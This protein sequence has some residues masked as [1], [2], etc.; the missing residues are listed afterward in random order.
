MSQ[1]TAPRS[2]EPLP[3]VI[4]PGYFAAATE[5]REMQQHLQALGYPTLVVPLRVADWYPTVGG[6]PVTPI[7][8]KIAETIAKAQQQFGVAQV[9]LVGHSAGGWISR[10][11]LGDQPYYDQI[12]GG[13]SQ[14][15]SLITLGTPHVSQERWTRF[16]LNFVND[17]YPGAHW[18]DLKYVCVAGKACFGVPPKVWQPNTWSGWLA[19]SSYQLTGGTGEVWGDGITPIT[20]AHLEGA[21]NL[22]VESV[23]HSPRGNRYWYGSA[24]VLA[25]WVQYLQ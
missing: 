5:Y 17:N 2:P 14:V 23:Y 20:A 8:L 9:N 22:T 13:R 15:A 21:V 18:P 12:W 1:P 10:I 19:Y 11:Y 24:A 3:T 4:V 16:N 6:R 25:D 7:M